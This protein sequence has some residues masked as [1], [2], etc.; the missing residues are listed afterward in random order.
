[1]RRDALLVGPYVA[2]GI[3]FAIVINANPDDFTVV[4][5]ITLAAAIVVGWGMGKA[6]LRRLH[7]C[8]WLPWV[9]VL[10][11]LPF[12]EASLPPGDSDV[13]PVSFYAVFAALPSMLAMLI[14]AGSRALYLRATAR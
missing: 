11:G 7:V 12:G 10:I 8:V 13:Y 3:A 5:F 2:A 4:W 9:I 1:M 6:G 14:A